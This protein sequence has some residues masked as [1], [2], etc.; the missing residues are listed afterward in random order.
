MMAERKEKTMTTERHPRTVFPADLVPGSLAYLAEAYRR[1]RL[2]SADDFHDNDAAS[3]ISE[4]ER[5]I[6]DEDSFL[7]DVREGRE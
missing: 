6:E 2:A 7:R 1:V 5:R 3:R 4:E